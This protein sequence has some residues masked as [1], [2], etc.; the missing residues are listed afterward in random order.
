MGNVNR[1]IFVSFLAV[2][3]AA[4]EHW[5][6]TSSSIT[7]DVRAAAAIEQPGLSSAGE[8]SH[9]ERAHAVGAHVA[10]RHRFDGFVEA[11]H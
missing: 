5:S 8:A 6:G 4:A 1:L 3:L 11:G 10:Q 7:V 9:G 2:A